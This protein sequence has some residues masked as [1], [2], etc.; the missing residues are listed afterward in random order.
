MHRLSGGQHV[1]GGR[2][3]FAK[4]VIDEAEQIEHV[5]VLTTRFVTVVM[6]TGVLVTPRLQAE[7]HD[8]PGYSYDLDFLGVIAV[9]EQVQHA[10]PIAGTGQ[11][12]VSP[13]PAYPAEMLFAEE[14]VILVVHEADATGMQVAIML[15]RIVLAAD[16]DPALAERADD[17]GGLAASPI[18]KVA[19]PET[20]FCHCGLPK[21]IFPDL[22]AA[23]A[24]GPQV[25]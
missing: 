20:L 8:V 21:L 1:V 23:L 25:L 4:F 24:A 2:E 10:S 18:F 7:E 16:V 9:L 19:V 22:A 17:N 15:G 11:R 5:G 6:V 12:L 3:S 13:H 14:N